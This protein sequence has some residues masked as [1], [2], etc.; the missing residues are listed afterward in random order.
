[1]YVPAVIS[2]IEAGL[3]KLDQQTPIFVQF[4]PP[5]GGFIW[6]RITDAGAIGLELS[7]NQNL[8]IAFSEDEIDFLERSMGWMQSAKTSNF[9]LELPIDIEP[10]VL[11]GIVMFSLECSFRNHVRSASDPDYWPNFEEAQEMQRRSYGRKYQ[12]EVEKRLAK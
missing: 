12:A 6:V 3:G 8:D 11:L 2:Q 4:S 9:T 5:E 7:G 10:D 1:M